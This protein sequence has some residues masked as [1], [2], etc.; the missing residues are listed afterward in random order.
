MGY[1]KDKD[2]KMFRNV[3]KK[4]NRVLVNKVV[5]FSIS[6]STAIGLLIGST[7]VSPAM[8]QIVSASPFLN[9]LFE[10]NPLLEEIK[11]ALDKKKYQYDQLS[12]STRE[13]EVIVGLEGSIENYNKVKTSVE[14]VIIEIL[15]ARNKDAYSVSVFHITEVDR[16]LLEWDAILEERGK[17]EYERVTEIAGEVLQ[18]YG[19]NTNGVGVGEGK[20]IHI[21]YIPNTEKRL[22]EIRNQIFKGLEKE[23][24]NGYKIKFYLFDPKTQEREDRLLPLYHTI[25]EGLTAKKEYKVDGT[26][27]SNKKEHFYIEVRTTLSSSD[28]DLEEVVEY[29]KSTIEDFLQSEEAQKVIKDDLYEIAI[30][31]KDKKKL[32]T[33]KN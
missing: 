16:R 31:S 2:S 32:K 14:D 18:Q 25:T 21:D 4:H 23:H 7:F 1:K 3:M 8:A 29:I 27:Y 17:E 20:K 10:T 24:L 5:V 9:L 12:V 11:A 33:I 13:K 26:G 28:S 19:H 22:D 30:L 6:F 15:K